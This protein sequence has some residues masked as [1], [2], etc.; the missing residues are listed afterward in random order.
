MFGRNKPVWADH[1]R[2][3]SGHI[4]VSL[5]DLLSPKIA[6]AAEEAGHRPQLLSAHRSG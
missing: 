2:R 3:G 5:P 4:D 1:H 6:E